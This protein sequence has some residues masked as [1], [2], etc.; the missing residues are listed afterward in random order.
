MSTLTLYSFGYRY[1]KPVGEVLSVRHFEGPPK[2]A[3]KLDG[4]S[5]RLQKEILA[6]NEEFYIRLQQRVEEL[7][8]TGVTQIYIGCEYGRHRSVAVVEALATEL[9][10]QKQHRD[11]ER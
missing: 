4:R 5:K 9:K 7:M 2:A 6:D 10:C 11:V 8:K 3:R 1:G